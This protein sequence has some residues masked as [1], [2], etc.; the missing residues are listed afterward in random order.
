VY[1]LTR[2]G[3]GVRHELH[4]YDTASFALIDRSTMT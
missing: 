3:Y 2:D 4:R 1:T